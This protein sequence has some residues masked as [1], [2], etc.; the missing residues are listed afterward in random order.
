GIARWS[1]LVLRSA[2]G[3]LGSAARTLLHG[4]HRS[5]Q[6]RVIGTT[7]VISV[8]VVTVLGIFLVQ[9]I[10]GGLLASERRQALTQVSAGLAYAQNQ[11]DMLGPRGAG[12]AELIS[13]ARALQA[14]SAPGNPDNVGIEQPRGAP[15][16]Q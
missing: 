2:G 5:L 9:Q 15:G 10:A 1:R 7:V 3:K 12:P 6:L 13:L 4:W 16:F 11:Q 8:A 14:R